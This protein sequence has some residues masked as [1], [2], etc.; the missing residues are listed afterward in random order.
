MH[1]PIC[2]GQAA[3]LLN[4]TEPA[5]NQLIRAGKLNPS[6]PVI[7]GRRLWS[8]Q[9]VLQAAEHLGV[10]TEELRAEL[11]PLADVETEA[12]GE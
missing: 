8:E 7:S 6:P 11:E 9:H 5:L 10:L 2:T 4:A 1:Y 3:E 12:R